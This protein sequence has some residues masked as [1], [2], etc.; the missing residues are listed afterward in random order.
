MI[1]AALVALAVVVVFFRARSHRKTSL[2]GL[3]S[4][5]PVFSVEPPARRLAPRKGEAL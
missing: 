1:I 5:R 4:A 2:A 3:D